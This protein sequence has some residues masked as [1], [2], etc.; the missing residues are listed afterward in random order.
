EAVH[1]SVTLWPMFSTSPPDGAV[2]ATAGAVVSA[3][4]A[5]IA[6]AC[7][8]VSGSGFVAPLASPLQPGNPQPAAGSAASVT[9]E[10]NAENGWFGLFG[11]EPWPSTVTDTGKRSGP[12]LAAGGCAACAVGDV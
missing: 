5:V 2:S 8:T 11:T 9:L 10:P 3:N 7:G 1:V 4:A 12:K 6:S